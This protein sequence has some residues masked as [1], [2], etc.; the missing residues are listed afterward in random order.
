MSLLEKVKQGVVLSDGAVGTQLMARGLKKGDPAEEWNVSHPDAVH[1]VIESYIEAGSQLVQTNTL[2]ANQPM[3]RERGLA[4]REDEINERGA[5]IALKCAEGTDVLVAASVGPTGL[6]FAPAG[7]LDFEAAVQIYTVQMRALKKAG[8]KIVSLE[9][10]GDISEMRAA[11]MAAKQL[12]GLEIISSMTYKG[13][14]TETDTPADACAVTCEALGADIVGANCGRGPGDM[15]KAMDL[16][17]RTASVPVSAKPS[18]GMPETENGT[19]KYPMTAEDFAQQMLPFAED[20]VRLLGGCCGTTPD[21]IRALKR[22]LD[23][24]EFPAIPEA[25]KG[26]YL[27]SPLGTVDLSR[28]DLNFAVMDLSPVV[29][30]FEIDNFHSVSDVLPVDWESC[31]VCV[32]DMAGLRADF[33]IQKLVTAITL[34]L[35]K[36]IILEQGSADVAELF[37]RYY[38]GRAGLMHRTKLPDQLFGAVLVGSGY[39]PY[40]E[41]GN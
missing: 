17:R 31:D 21:F 38:P 34:F 27:A 15:R 22:E 5:E 20:G 25:K 29:D 33:D 9:S 36:P 39:R 40:E 13:D 37:L 23:G 7:Y 32:V 28:E 3:L 8:I 2:C 16:I 19:L 26:P 1:K 30:Q 4:E 24:K 10:M 14:R 12:G 35:K 6:H 41:A 11:I 18:A